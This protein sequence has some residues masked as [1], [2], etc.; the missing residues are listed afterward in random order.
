MGK[1]DEAIL[2][3]QK[4]ISI[5]TEHFKD[6]S[7]S[8]DNQASV[9]FDTSPAGVYAYAITASNSKTGHSQL[10][11]TLQLLEFSSASKALKKMAKRFSSKNLVLKNQIR[12]LQDLEIRYENSKDY[13]FKVRDDVAVDKGRIKEAGLNYSKV[14]VLKDLQTG[15]LASDFPKYT[16]LSNSKP[17]SLTQL[18]TLLR[19]DEA[20]V[21]ITFEKDS[22]AAFVILVRKNNSKIYKMDLS[23]DQMSSIVS[24]LRKQLDLSSI[25]Q[26][27]DLLKFDTNLS[28][29]LYNSIFGPATD[30][31]SGVRHLL[32]VPKGP[33]ES[34]PFNVLVTDTSQ[35]HKT[36][37][38]DY[39]LVPWLPKKYT[40]TTL[41]TI[42]SL[43]ALR[44]L[45]KPESSNNLF[46]GFGNPNF[47][48]SSGN[49]RNIK[50]EDFYSGK[51]ANL[52]VIRSLPELPE[53]AYELKAISKYLGASDNSLFLA[54]R[55]TETSVK[56]TDL[57]KV[58]VL[59]FA[60]HGLIGGEFK[61]L[62]ESALVLTP[63]EVISVDDDGLLTVSEIVQLK[64]NADWVLLSSCNSAS[65]VN[66]GAEGLSGL[67]RAFLYAGARSLLV[68]H[69]AIESNAAATIT[70]GAF[71]EL[72][73]DPGIGRAEALRRSMVSLASGKGNS[74]Y[75]H[76]AFWAPFVLVGEGRPFY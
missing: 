69:W 37:E 75:T 70:I 15:K 17:L 55:A 23:K 32:V 20:L 19:K 65:G 7:R 25:S 42:S 45:P 61:G 16:E 28:N 3:A 31:L 6:R 8:L 33:L 50:V 66:L 41:P 26:Q 76:P 60:T 74:M 21:T 11:E 53:T 49:L 4:A 1:N 56:N 40:L 24:D 54:D 63:P 12:N 67:A 48:G 5:L 51:G 27:S 38:T 30:F 36:L 34:L 43:R 9:Y 62:E 10:I 57:S 2:Y 39:R 47:K 35:E 71:E 18:Q 68:S 73:K 29:S 59:A 13:F 22:K 44:M 72:S 52:S 58:K 46:V 14:K 64:L